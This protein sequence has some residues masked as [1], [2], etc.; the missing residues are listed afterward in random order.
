LHSTHTKK[1]REI[2]TGNIETKPY[3]MSFIAPW[4]QNVTFQTP[5]RFIFDLVFGPITYVH[6]SWLMTEGVLSQEQR[7]NG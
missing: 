1:L 7:Q 6:E 5:Q 3:G 4:Q 2:D